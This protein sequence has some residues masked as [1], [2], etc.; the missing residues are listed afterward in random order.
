M[1]QISVIRQVELSQNGKV[2]KPLEVSFI[3]GLRAWLAVITRDIARKCFQY[4]HRQG[5][6]HRVVS[7]LYHVCRH[8]L[9][10]SIYTTRYP[11]TGFPV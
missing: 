6:L 1:Q 10:N 7:Y 4:K 11:V 2:S 9:G 8:N 5:W 3:I